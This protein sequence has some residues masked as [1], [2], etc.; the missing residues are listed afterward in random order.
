MEDHASDHSFEPVYSPQSIHDEM[1]NVTS[2]TQCPYLP[3]KKARSEVY[4]VDLLDGDLYERLLARGFR[5]CGRIIYRPRCRK[6]HECRQLR[7]RVDD[8]TPSRSLRRVRR[9][10]ADV[11]VGSGKLEPTKEKHALFTRYLDSQHDD[12]MS[13]TYD[14]FEESLYD[15]PMETCEFEY[16]LGERL[17]GVSIADRCPKGLSSIYMYFDPDF[18]ARSLGTFSALWEIEHCRNAGLCYYYLGFYVANSPTMAYKA[19]FCPNEILVGDDHWLSLRQV[20]P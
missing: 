4:G 8:F 3:A 10:N 20:E 11:S 13:R 2:E 19:R 1:R 12:T 15:S 17:V 14:S 6:C 16:R 5:R 18:R 7:V 9:R